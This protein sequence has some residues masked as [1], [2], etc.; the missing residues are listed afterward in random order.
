[1]TVISGDTSDTALVE[2]RDV[3]AVPE[4]LKRDRRQVDDQ[5]IHVSM[6]WRSTLYVTNFPP[7]TD[8]ES[9][10]TMFSNVSHGRM[11]LIQYGVVLQTR[12]PA[13]KYAESRRFCYITM[14]S[15]VSR[16]P[17]RADVRRM[18]KML[19]FSMVTRIDRKLNS[20]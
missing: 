13:K 3:S 1:M 20:A 18:P 11:L 9:I 8:D 6:L 7:A 2:F 12:W 14:S 10:R 17:N 5:Q 16:E 4:A 19:W 15:P